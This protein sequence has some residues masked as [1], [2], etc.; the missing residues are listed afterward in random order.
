MWN[1]E[2]TNYGFKITFAGS[3][4]PQEMSAWV[5]ES[6]KQLR[7]VQKGFT[8]LIDLTKLGTLTPATKKT[9][10]DGQAL[11]KKMG[12]LRSCVLCET[13][14]QKMQFKN[15]ATASG[16]FSFEHYVDVRDNPG[17]MRE[18]MTWLDEGKR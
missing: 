9:M 1:I 3:I 2:K 17:H 10:E 13:Y 16:I 15:I 11:Y 12:M 5:M 8:V 6:I 4:A 18:A 7:G 14:L